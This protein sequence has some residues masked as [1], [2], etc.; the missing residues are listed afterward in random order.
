LTP[1]RNMRRMSHARGIAFRKKL[2]MSDDFCGVRGEFIVS[3]PKGS[4]CIRRDLRAGTAEVR[5]GRVP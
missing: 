3:L 1:R 5:K 4:R 2:P